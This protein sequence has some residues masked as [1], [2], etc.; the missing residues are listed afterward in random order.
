MARKTRKAFAVASTFL[1]ENKPQPSDEVAGDRPPFWPQ[2]GEVMWTMSVSTI[3]TDRAS[4]APIHTNANNA[5]A[6]Q[7]STAIPTTPVICL[8]CLILGNE[9]A[10]PVSAARRFLQGTFGVR[11]LLRG[12]P[13]K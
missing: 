1:H 9:V 10:R 13:L 8:S 12:T 7:R 6:A 4:T 3:I 5:E 2:C 11:C